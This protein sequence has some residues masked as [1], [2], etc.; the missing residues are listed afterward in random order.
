[1]NGATGGVGLAAVQVARALNCRQII[2]TGR[3]SEKLA[4]VA[5][6]GATCCLNLEE[7]VSLATALKAQTNGRGVDV[8]FD[9]IGGEVFDESLRGT[10]WGARV[11]VVGFA[12]GKHPSIRANY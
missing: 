7:E 12:S 8:V 11:L 1:V 4:V 6:H 5:R 9:T 10:A 2:A 3:G